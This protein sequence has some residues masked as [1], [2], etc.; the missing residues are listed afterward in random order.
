[1]AKIISL[2]K[3]KRLYQVVFDDERTIYVTEDTIVRF[4]LSKGGEFNES[5][6]VEITE[7]ADFSRGKNLGLYYLSFKQR[8]KKEVITYLMDHEI[9]NLQIAKIIDELENSRFIDDVAYTESFIRGKILGKTS[10]PYQIQ[11][12]LSEK[13]LDKALIKEK[14][15]LLYDDDTQL[16]VATSLAEKL[17]MSKY[18]RLPLQA[19]K[20]KLTTHLTSK[21][22]SYDVSKAAITAL[23]LEADEDNETELLQKELEKVLRRYSRKY[24]GY[25]LKQR[26]IQALARKGY[27]FE[28]IRR[29]LRDLDF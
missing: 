2:E 22:F 9:P 4:F 7:F 17:V 23:E 15:S 8:T 28:L 25:D 16:D 29:E 1:M 27:D 18:R 12:K 6:I 19:L 10:G 3:K 24:D 21:G 14:L 11:Q 26:I 13:G 20:M 5:E